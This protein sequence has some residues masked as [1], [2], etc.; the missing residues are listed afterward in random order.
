MQGVDEMLRA[1]EEGDRAPFAHICITQEDN[2]SAKQNNDKKDVWIEKAQ[3]FINEVWG[4]YYD[5]LDKP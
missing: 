2:E 4:R 5:S 1:I 3:H